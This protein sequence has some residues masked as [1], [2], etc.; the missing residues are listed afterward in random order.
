MT[1]ASLPIILDCLAYDDREEA[2]CA[3]LTDE[4]TFYGRVF[5]GYLTALSTLAAIQ[6]RGDDSSLLSVNIVFVGSVRPGRVSFLPTTVRE[7]KSTSVTEVRAT[8]NGVTT[9]IAH[10]RFGS[11]ESN[12]ESAAAW[13][14]DHLMPDDCV[15]PK[16]VRDNA[17]FL[18]HFD[19]RVIDFPLGHEE[20]RGGP[21]YIELWSR[22]DDSAGPVPHQGQLHDLM[23]FDS[24]LLDSVFRVLGW[25]SWGVRIVSL[26]LNVTWLRLG[27]STGWRRLRAD[28]EIG[29]DA[30]AIN[31]RLYSENGRLLAV[32]ASQVA[33]L[34]K[35]A[36]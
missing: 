25:V 27:E 18:A 34:Q 13:T 9:S 7:T 24:H 28:A 19:E 6:A 30:A 33:V 8:Q 17:A 4:W 32:A 23:I 10:V 14:G 16:W 3:D 15:P 22:P 2:Y 12:T 1:S 26:D 31:A 29:G 36:Q 35:A 20:F 11:R 21:P 5:G